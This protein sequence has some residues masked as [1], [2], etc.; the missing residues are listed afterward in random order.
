VVCCAVLLQDAFGG[1]V[2]RAQSRSEDVAIR[3]ENASDKT[4]DGVLVTFPDK[5]QEN[6]GRI[7]AAS[8]SS[9]RTVTKAYR[10]AY[11]EITLG[12]ELAIIQ[13]VDFFGETDLPAGRYTYRLTLNAN[14]RSRWDRVREIL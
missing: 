12:D 2:F 11:M 8:F 14:S 9:Y 5:H 6:Y 4:F 10:G 3:I 1:P 7:P 13:P